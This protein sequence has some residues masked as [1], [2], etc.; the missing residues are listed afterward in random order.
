MLTYFARERKEPMERGK[1]A[2]A[3]T[4]NLLKLIV[5]YIYIFV[6]GTNFIT[7]GYLLKIHSCMN[8]V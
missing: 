2:Y 5:T 8:D 3:R 1:M 4:L 7:V 6:K